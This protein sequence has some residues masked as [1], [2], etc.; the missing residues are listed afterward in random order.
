VATKGLSAAELDEFYR[1]AGL[2]NENLNTKR[3][4]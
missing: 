2:M 3:R 1:L 4:R